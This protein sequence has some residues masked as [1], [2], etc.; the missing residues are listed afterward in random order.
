MNKLQKYLKPSFGFI[1]LNIIGL[2]IGSA[3]TDPGTTSEWYSS[4]VKAPWTPP[5][6]VFGTAWS[7]IAMTFGI[8]MSQLWVKRNLEAIALFITSFM[9]NVLWNPLFF[10]L[11][12]VWISSLVIIMLTV[13]IFTLIH[14]ARTQYSWKMSFWA[15]P[16][17]IWLIIATSLNLYVA[18]MN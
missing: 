17:A 7:T 16:Y 4:V 5:G 18:I 9:L 13:N 1:L 6:W 12:W 15:F 10:Y 8:F 11:H 14:L 2:A 3:W